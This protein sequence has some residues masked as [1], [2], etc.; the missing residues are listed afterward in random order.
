MKNLIILAFAIA[1]LNAFSAQLECSNAGKKIVIDKKT[2]T[3]ESSQ[4]EL[5]DD[6]RALVSRSTGTSDFTGV[7]VGVKISLPA[8]DVDCRELMAKMI[9]CAGSTKKASVSLSISQQGPFMSSSSQSFKKPVKIDH[10]QIDTNLVSSG[11]V[12]LGET[13]V[14]VSLDKVLVKASM[15]VNMNGGFALDLEQGFSLHPECK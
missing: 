7:R 3:I 9:N 5:N 4:V 10:I 1:S 8:K 11:P 6:L 13:P 14:T 2:V 12:V 15:H